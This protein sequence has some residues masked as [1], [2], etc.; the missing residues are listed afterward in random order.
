MTVIQSNKSKSL[1]QL[2]II[3]G[4]ILASTASLY[5]TLYSKTVSLKHDIQNIGSELSDLK[6]KN[7]ELKNSFYSVVDSRELEKLAQE[8]GLI[9]DKNPKW[10]FAS[11]R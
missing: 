9:Y 6:V 2:M 4:V 10:E 8:K 11:Q 3:F 7:A 5:V 1:I